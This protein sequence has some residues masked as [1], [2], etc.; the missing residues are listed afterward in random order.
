MTEVTGTD[1]YCSHECPV[2][3]SHLQGL[4][5]R[6]HTSEFTRR[7]SA[8]LPRYIHQHTS[9]RAKL[10][11]GTASGKSKSP[12]CRTR[13]GKGGSPFWFGFQQELHRFNSLYFV[14]KST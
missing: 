8:A 6:F 9:T 13:R 5:N 7:G 2:A 4:R 12:P 3:G 10:R 1:Q 11:S 14:M